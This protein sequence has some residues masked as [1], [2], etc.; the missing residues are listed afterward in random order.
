MTDKFKR[1]I[2][3][4]PGDLDHESYERLEAYVDGRLDEVDMEIVQAHLDMC[5]RCGEDASDLEDTKTQLL[6]AM[7]GRRPRRSWTAAAVAAGV[8]L[9]AVVS[10]QM[11][12]GDATVSP[13]APTASTAVAPKDD[14][15]RPAERT[16]INAALAAGV[17]EVPA[18]VRSLAGVE[19]TLLGR[20]SATEAMGPLSPAGTAVANAAPTFSWRAMDAAAS[21]TATVFDESFREVAASGPLTVTTWT[22]RL[23]LPRGRVFVW[24]V[25]ARLLDGSEALAPAPPHP[26]ARFV[27]LDETT[28]AAVDD[29]RARL[30]SRP[31]DLGILLAGAGLIDD[32][33]RELRRAST[34][35][36]DP[37]TAT[38]AAALLSTLRAR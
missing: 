33:E 25:R 16:T 34:S 35:T 30:A 7:V 18:A 4:E 1:A 36:G 8:L 24:Q 12:R 38:A 27:V 23:A 29:Q 17:I 9:A 2:A 21:Y 15:L 13:S 31:L 10:W 26:E 3:P 32:A 37:A 5:R 6:P 11:R 20:A 28:A 14:G 22:P 19:G